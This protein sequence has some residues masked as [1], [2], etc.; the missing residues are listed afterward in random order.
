M[1]CARC[2]DPCD[3]DFNGECEECAFVTVAEE[4]MREREETIRVPLPSR[5]AAGEFCGTRYAA[6]PQDQETEEDA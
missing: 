6:A 1:K 5:V 4:A 3:A 2:G